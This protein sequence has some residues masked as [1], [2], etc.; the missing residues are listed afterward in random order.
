MPAPEWRRPGAAV[1]AG[2][3]VLGAALVTF[4][5]EIARGHDGSPYYQL[6]ALGGA[7]YALAVVYLRFSR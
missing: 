6:A 2:M 7:A 4:M 5:V 1:C 3:T